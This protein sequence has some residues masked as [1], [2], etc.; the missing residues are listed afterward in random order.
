MHSYLK[1]SDIINGELKLFFLKFYLFFPIWD[2][3]DFEKF[4]LLSELQILSWPIAPSNFSPLCLKAEWYQLMQI[5]LT[6]LLPRLRFFV[7][8]ASITNLQ[9]R[10]V[11]M[12]YS[13]NI[14]KDKSGPKKACCIKNQLCYDILFIKLNTYWY[15]RSL[16]L[17]GMSYVSKK[18]AHL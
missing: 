13:T 11:S 7:A 14:S 4:S 2:R 17:I 5:Q 10:Y 16:S 18:N 9:L 3:K 1:I 8:N 6:K 15:R 12:T